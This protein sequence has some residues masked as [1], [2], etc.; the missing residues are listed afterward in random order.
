MPQCCGSCRV[1]ANDMAK[2]VDS[3]RRKDVYEYEG[4]VSI[5]VPNLIEEIY[6]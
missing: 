3:A 2:H 6:S 1:N 5:Q 4:V